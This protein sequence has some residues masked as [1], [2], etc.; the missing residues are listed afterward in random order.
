MIWSDHVPADVAD[1]YA[2]HEQHHAAALLAHEF[3]AQFSDLCDA[4]RAFTITEEMI[5]KPGGNESDIPKVMSTL[6]RPRGWVEGRLTASMTV[7]GQTQRQDT[8]KVDYLKG[9]VAFDMEWNSKDQTFDRDLYAFRTFFEFDRISVGVILT[10]SLDL[11][12]LFASLGVKAKYGAST[13]HMGKLLSRLRAG[14]S[15]GCPVLVLCITRK[16]VTR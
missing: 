15:G 5:T 9:R 14:R 4:L 3:P 11:D 8:H 7:D 2:V 13:T 1:R 6:L 10:R 12:R 16:V